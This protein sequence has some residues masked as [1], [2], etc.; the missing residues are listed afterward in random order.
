MYSA[1]DQMAESVD[2]LVTTLGHIPEHILD[3]LDGHAKLHIDMAV[4]LSEDPRIVGNNE[5]VVNSMLHL[6]YR[7]LP[8][9][10]SVCR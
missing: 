10:A 1:A 4:H 8:N 5:L 6:L 2:C 9:V 3:V 7:D